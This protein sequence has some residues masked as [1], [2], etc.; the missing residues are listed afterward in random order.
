MGENK[1]LDEAI[2]Q[3]KSTLKDLKSKDMYDSAVAKY[4]RERELEKKSGGTDIRKK[5][6][7]VPDEG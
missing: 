4:H 2:D 3:F 5:G 1:N 7:P 6:S